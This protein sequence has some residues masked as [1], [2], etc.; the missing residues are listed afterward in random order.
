MGRVKQNFWLNHLTQ[1]VP[2]CSGNWRK[3]AHYE[4]RNAP[5][6]GCFGSNCFFS[7]QKDE[8]L[9][10]PST[11]VESE[12]NTILFSENFSDYGLIQIHK[13]ESGVLLFS[14]KAKIGSEAEKRMAA[15]S[16]EPSLVDIYRALMPDRK[17]VPAAIV[18]ASEYLIQQQANHPGLPS[19]NKER[20]L[21]KGA[22]ESA[23]RTNY[24]RDIREYPW[25]WRWQTCDW[26]AN[27]N[28]IWTPFVD[29]SG[30]IMDRVYAYNPTPYTATLTLWNL[31]RNALASSWRPTLQPYWV[32]WFQWGGSY[33]FAIAEM[34]L[35]SRKF[36][37]MGLSTHT[38]VPL[39]L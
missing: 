37:E 4:S 34:T 6:G 7:C 29:A 32:T 26:T 15:V 14:L 30:G 35:P 1:Q 2:E 20:V 16:A 8:A 10:S 19:Q 12:S 5:D 25:E 18:S 33:R 28:S 13:D 38:P 23:F 21:P 31:E 36:G 27:S 22:S 17:S 3:D 11:P 9:V 39:V 24:C